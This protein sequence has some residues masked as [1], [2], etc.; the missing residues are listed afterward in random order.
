MTRTVKCLSNFCRQCCFT[1]PCQNLALMFDN[2]HICK[3][4]LSQGS[5]P[6]RGRALTASQ[7]CYS[8]V[9]L[10]TFPVSS[11]SSLPPSSLCSGRA[12]HL[13]Q[14]AAGGDDIIC[15][16]AHCSTGSEQRHVSLLL[17][18]PDSF[19]LSLCL[20]LFPHIRQRQNE[21]TTLDEGICL[22]L[23]TLLSTHTLRP[24]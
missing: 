10:F 11:H 22:N 19:L 14:Q 2:D 4:A 15:T 20:Y 6:E 21:S 7:C 16:A 5:I 1:I 23:L 3:R 17:T 12:S 8:T 24:E 18:I 9:W 13:E